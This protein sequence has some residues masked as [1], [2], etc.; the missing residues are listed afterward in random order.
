MAADWAIEAPALMRRAL[1]GPS[2]HEVSGRICRER[3]KQTHKLKTPQM[4]PSA[5]FQIL[6]RL[7]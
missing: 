3:Y 6:I 2:G 4:F 5:A 1:A 7:Y